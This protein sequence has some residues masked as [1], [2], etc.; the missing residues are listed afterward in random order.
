M[1]TW[2]LAAGA[3]IC[4]AYLVVI[5]LYSG[6]ASA[7]IWLMFAAVLGAAS[8]STFRLEKHPEHA[9]LRLPV[10]LVTLIGAG[11]V[12]LLVLQIMMFGRIPAVAEPALDYVIVLGAH[13]RQ[14]GPSKTL[15]LR[16]D[17]AAE[18]ALQNPETTLILSGGKG[19]DEPESE[20]EAMQ[21]YLLEKGVPQWQMLLE[22]NSTSTLENMAYSWTMIQQEKVRSHEEN[23]RRRLAREGSSPI[24]ALA[25][26]TEPGLARP[27][28][29][30]VV[31]SNFH[32][33]RATKIAQKQGITDVRGIAAGS[34]PVLLI[35]YA[36]RDALAVLKDRLAGNL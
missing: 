26:E 21:A 8:W 5:M 4:L 17:K 34:D 6:A 32:L 10:T 1:L 29:I 22:K 28:R 18:Y 27:V 24:H 12:I 13:V 31:T 11:L 9:M 15:R 20:A 33:Y 23:M 35:H 36:V 19:E 30:G 14:E 16:L 7:W 3:V 2:I 25:D